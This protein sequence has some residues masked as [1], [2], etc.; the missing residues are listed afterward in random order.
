MRMSILM[1]KT[2][3]AWQAR[4][5][6]GRILQQ[7]AARGDRIVVERHGEALAAVVPMEVYE[8]WKRGRENFFDKLQKAA[9]QANCT[10]EEADE[11]AREAVAAVR[12]ASS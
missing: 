12:A 5:E 4:R 3:G 2:I 11:L 6:F 9:R 7:V 8:Q 1:E 10:P